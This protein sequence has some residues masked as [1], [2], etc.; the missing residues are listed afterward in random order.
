[1]AEGHALGADRQALSCDDEGRSGS[2]DSGS[3]SLAGDIRQLR[4]SGVGGVG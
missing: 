4:E 1:M 2:G 3:R